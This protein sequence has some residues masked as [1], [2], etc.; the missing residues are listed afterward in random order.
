MKKLITFIISITMV[1]AAVP[2]SAAVQTIDGAKSF[3]KMDKKTGDYVYKN[4]EVTIPSNVGESVGEKSGEE[5][6]PEKFD[7]REEGRSTPV[8][9]QGE[10]EF[11]WAHSVLASFESY[12]ISKG[13]A[14]KNIDLSE[15]H[16]AYFTFNGERNDAFSKYGGRDTRGGSPGAANYYDATASLARGYGAVDESLFPY[17]KYKNKKES[18]PKKYTSD[19]MMTKSKY[20]LTDAVFIS[21]DPKPTDYDKPAVDT[22]KR[23]LME[24]GALATQMN[25][26]E[27]NN[28]LLKEFGAM[29]VKELKAYYEKDEVDSIAGA[30]HAV[31][32]I[33]WDDTFNDFPSANV[34]DIEIR[35]IIKKKTEVVDGNKPAGPGA[36]IVKDSYG[37][38]IHGGGY[39][40][41]SYYSTNLF[42]YISFQGRK[43]TGK[44]AYQ[45]DG[46]GVGENMMRFDEKVAGAN[47]YTARTDLMLD[48]LASYTPTADGTVNFKVYINQNGKSPVS[49]KLAYN[50]SYKKK[51]SGYSRM[52]MSKK[53]AIPKGTKFSIVVTTKTNEGKY[54]APFEVI[55]YTQP[56]VSPAAV[57]SGQSYIQ[58]SGKWKSVT[59]NTILTEKGNGDDN[60]YQVFNALA[61]GFGD[62]GGSKAQNIKVKTKRSVKKGKKLKLKAKVTKGKG[63]LLYQVSN[64]KKATVSAE[65]VVKAKK[66]GTVKVTIYAT[67]TSKYKS[68]K[69]VVKIKIK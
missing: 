28:W 25:Y 14:D 30:G 68:A 33:G 43:S 54:Y 27:G 47:T 13:L 61:K 57:R 1:L 32:I 31:S 17:G 39:F 62:K 10:F 60:K 21:A 16:L 55:D 23:M 50:K 29:N 36:W 46:V 15:A 53:V 7:L 2:A 9:D 22:A 49:G 4:P 58:Q 11:C 45:Y 40:Y 63:K 26:P 35:N 12:L 52:D 66:K 67:P 59:N 18:I 34:K 51:Y 64:T 6:L 19:E 44:Q 69:K 38:I 24:N 41:M 5:P 8:K 48:Q 20:E 42:R 37:S 3:G 65:G 56:T